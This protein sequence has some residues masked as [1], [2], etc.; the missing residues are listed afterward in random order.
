LPPDRGDY[1]VTV[2]AD[3]AEPVSKDVAVDGAAIYRIA[4]SLPSKNP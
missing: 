2:K 4:L 1:R 3:G